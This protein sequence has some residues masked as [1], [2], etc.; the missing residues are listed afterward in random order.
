[1]KCVPE[2]RD[3]LSCGLKVME[4]TQQ[5]KQI[6]QSPESVSPLQEPQSI[7][8][9]QLELSFPWIEDSEEGART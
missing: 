1:M 9:T 6:S 5:G 4:R 7:V 8:T 3:Q 2:K